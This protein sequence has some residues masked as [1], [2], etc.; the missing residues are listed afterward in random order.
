MQ[1]IVII[2]TIV[3]DI[4]M[5]TPDPNADFWNNALYYIFSFLGGGGVGFF[6]GIKYTNSKRKRLTKSVDQSNSSVSGIQAGRDVK[7][8]KGNNE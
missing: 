2:I 6:C 5:P 8:T 7:L 4:F 1:S 3:E